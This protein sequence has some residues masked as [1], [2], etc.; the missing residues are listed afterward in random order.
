MIYSM[1]FGIVCVTLL[2]CIGILGMFSDR[3]TWNNGICKKNGLPWILR[4][5]GMAGDRLYRAGD[6]T[7]WISSPFV[8]NNK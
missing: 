5:V 6:E 4:D 2:L 1:I 7:C 8:G 3:K